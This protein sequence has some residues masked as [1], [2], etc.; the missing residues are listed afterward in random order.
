MIDIGKPHEA[1]G[2][3]LY[4]DKRKSVSEPASHNPHG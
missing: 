2:P 1:S 4:K 3:V